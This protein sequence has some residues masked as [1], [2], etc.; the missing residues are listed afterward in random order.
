MTISTL[1]DKIDSV[2]LVRNQIA[3]ILALESTAQVALAIAAGK[4]APDLWTLRVYQER[5]NP[6]EA[7]PSQTCD[8][9]PVVNV[10]LDTVTF[11][12]SSSNI[13]ERQKA[14]AIIN[15]DCYG[16]GVSA[17]DG[18]LGHLAGDRNAAEAAQRAVRLVRNILTSAKYTYLGLRGL[19]WRR[20]VES[21]T[22]MQPQQGG[23]NVHHVTAGRVSLKIEFNE[24]SPQFP[25][26]TLELLTIDVHRTED[27]QI[28]VEADYDY[29]AA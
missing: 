27:D 22:M 14:S 28:I 12:T 3:A 21:I 11:E 2:E 17:D 6:W 7:F 23:Q 15:V 5:A 19:V 25:L 1:I 8:T 10:W 9:S 29:T 24:F 16:Y 26:E 13:V 4:P 20:W 18:D